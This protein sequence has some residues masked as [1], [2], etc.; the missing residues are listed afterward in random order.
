[1]KINPVNLV[2]RGVLFGL[3]FVAPFWLL[4]CLLLR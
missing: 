3:L 4:V 2:V 1:M